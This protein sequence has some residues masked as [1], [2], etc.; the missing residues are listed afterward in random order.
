MTRRNTSG[1]HTQR[2]RTTRNKLLVS[3][4]EISLS[5]QA[6]KTTGHQ[7]QPILNSILFYCG[8]GSSV[9]IATDY[10]L[11][12]PGIETR[13][14]RVFSHTSRPALGPPSLLYNGYRVF[15]G[16]KA[17]GAW[18][19]PP[20][21][22]SVEVENELYLYS[23]SRPLLVCYRVTFTFILFYCVTCATCFGFFINHIIGHNCQT[24]NRDNL[25]RHR[26]IIIYYPWTR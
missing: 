9:G 6:D 13:W 18:C 8:P 19:W 5:E 25:S 12:G 21:R 20:T 17:V 15:P 14:G 11:D 22:S 26:K 4:W 10:G 2:R 23:P 16:G 3:G 7:S 1:V 24:H